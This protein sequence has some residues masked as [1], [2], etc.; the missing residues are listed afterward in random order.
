[1]KIILVLINLA[2]ALAGTALVILGAL[3]IWGQSII[4]SFI[5]P[6][7]TATKNTFSSSVT[8]VEAANYILGLLRN[9]GIPVFVI[10]LFIVA[11]AILGVC[12]ACCDCFKVLLIPYAIV[13]GLIVAAQIICLIVI[14]VKK[15]SFLKDQLQNTIEKFENYP[16]TTVETLIWTLVQVEVNCCGVNNGSDYSNLTL[17][18]RTYTDS[19]GK[20]AQLSYPVSCCMYDKNFKIVDSTCP[21]SFNSNNSYINTGC[22]TKL[23]SLLTSYSLSGLIIMILVI[24]A[25]TALVLMACYVARSD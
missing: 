15:D 8:A 25:Q 7:L 10:G 16:V 19:Q 9:A 6:F 12:G 22:Y 24:V 20:A 14:Y 13:T 18:N 2:V 23:S 5:D 3:I 11:V 17:W 1:M 4:T 21:A